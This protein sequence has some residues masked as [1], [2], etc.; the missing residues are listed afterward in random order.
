MMQKEAKARIKINDLLQNAGWR[1]FDDEKGKANIVL[2][3]NAKITKQA[4]DEFGNDFEKTKKGFIDF[5]LLDEKGFPFVVLE[6]K[7]EDKDPL[8][9][10][11]QARRYAQSQNARFIILSNGN[12][13]YLWDVERGNPTV[14]I[15]FPTYESLKHFESFKPS[16]TT[17]SEE[18]VESDYI[19]QTQNPNY[20]K[21]PRWIDET[22]RPDFIKELDLKFLRPYQLSAVHALQGSAKK[23]NDRYLFEM[24]T[25]TG[26]TLIAGGIIKL[27][28]KSGNAKRILFLVDRLELEDQAWKNFVRFLKNDFTCVI[29]KE[30]KD[31]WRKAEIVVST[32]Q[33]LS[34]NNKYKKLFSPTDFDMIISDEAH[35]SIGGNSRA[36]FEYFVGYKLGL[37]ATPKDYLKNI[38]PQ[39]VSEKDPRAWERRQL[40][41]TYTTF[42]CPSGEPTFRYSLLDGVKDGFLVNPIVADARTEITTELLSEKGYSLMVENEEGI[43]EE[44]TF[45]Q[46]DFE[47]KFFSDKTNQIFCKTFLE[48]AIK[49]PISGEIGKSIIFCVS[50]NH[51]SKITQ[52]LN[53]F[54]SQLWP[55]K[56]N[57]DFAVQVTSNIPDSQQFTI[58]YA[59]NNLNGQTKWLA[60]YKSSK[61]RVCVTVGMMTTGYDCQ[62][63]MNLC[64]MRP[65][66]SPTDFIQIK[67][68]G[69][70][71]YTFGYKDADGETAKIEK[72]TF[73]LFDYFANC[74]YF[75]EKY[76]YDQVLKLPIKTGTGIGGGEG[77]D[78]DEVNIFNPD[79]LKTFSEKAV[80]IAGMKVDWKFFD[81]FESVV[82]NNPVVKQKYDQGD[83]KGAE[84]YVKTEIFEKPEDYFNLDKLRKSVKADRRITLKEFIEKIFGGINKFKSKDEL[85]EDEFE[86]FVTIY[87]PDSKYALPIKNYLKAYITD[88]EIRDIIETKEYSRFATN[89]KVTMKDFRELNGYR[90]VVPEYVKDYVSINAFM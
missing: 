57:S 36:V 83:V 39:K 23:G 18:K 64:L 32:V 27:F 86:K 5:L 85:L 17:L 13:H 1:F 54:A 4:I 70:R 77:V 15:T 89:P 22:Q 45:F 78:I 34:F 50:Q 61:T 10:K 37:T 35:R 30:N 43:E 11:E 68:R 66:F 75:E 6:A 81:K 47:R 84:E 90:E 24:A 69:T 52:T 53:Q 19:V 41:D 2:E 40:L 73:K 25:G 3:N 88:S 76:N 74:E 26:K 29:Y 12:L 51:A 65:I 28:L 80:G 82:K 60:G 49:D 20:Q 72:D 31:D 46:K 33:S 9:G 8:D 58:N 7:S 79:P 48:N 44:Q 14:I 55:D 87:K 38:D 16:F 56:Y 59:N 71:K 21:D 62:D 63:V 42:G 67:G